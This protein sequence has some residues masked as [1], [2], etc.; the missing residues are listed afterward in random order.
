MS[1]NKQIDKSKNIKG[2]CGIANLKMYVNNNIYTSL[3]TS[4]WDSPFDLRLSVDTEIF[5][6]TFWI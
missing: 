3:S 5:C 6:H 4:F 2:P 1:L